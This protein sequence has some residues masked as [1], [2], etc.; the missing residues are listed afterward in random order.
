M[1]P[2]K[3]VL[4]H[5]FIS[6]LY[7]NKE[8]CKTINIKSDVLFCQYSSTVQKV[9]SAFYIFWGIIIH[10]SRIINQNQINLDYQETIFR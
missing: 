7:L 9:S 1:F 2:V 4:M 3:H 6:I 5:F 8:V 10:H